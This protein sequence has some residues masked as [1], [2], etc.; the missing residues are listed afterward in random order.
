[1]KSARRP[2]EDAARCLRL[3]ANSVLSDAVHA[4]VVSQEAG[5]VRPPLS[6]HVADDVAFL[7]ALAAALNQEADRIEACV[8]TAGDRRAS[9]A[10]S[11]TARAPAM[12]PANDSNY[13]MGPLIAEIGRNIEPLADAPADR[14][15]LGRLKDIN[16][17]LIPL[18]RGD[19]MASELPED[20][21][22]DEPDQLR[23]SRG[24]IIWTLISAVVWLALLMRFFG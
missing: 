20:R 23:T 14:R 2:R 15:R 4:D 5:L 13:D 17:G 24:I 7:A 12:S 3:V 1:M 18:L 22:D 16:P 11:G 9:T 6:S 21:C 10:T 8:G 19:A